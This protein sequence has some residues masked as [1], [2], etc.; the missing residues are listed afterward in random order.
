[1][2]PFVVTYISKNLIFFKKFAFYRRK[3][4]YPPVVLWISKIPVG[5][6]KIPVG[7]IKIPVGKIKIIVS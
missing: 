5:K 3:N 7:K 1:M 2:N 4:P 6:I